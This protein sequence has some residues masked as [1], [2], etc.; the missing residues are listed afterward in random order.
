MGFGPNF[1]IGIEGFTSTSTKTSPG[2][3][4]REAARLSKE[5]TS[6]LYFH[7]MY[8]TS[9]SSNF[10]SNHQYAYKYEAMFSFIARY[11]LDV[12]WATTSESPFTSSLRIPK[13]MAIRKP[14]NSPS[15]SAILLV[16]VGLVKSILIAYLIASP[17]G[18]T[19]TTPAPV[20]FLHFA[21]S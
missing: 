20:P 1:G 9:S 4:C 10:D 6:V 3:C 7:G 12:C 18:D 2:R 8:W 11:P 17:S 16:G 15:Y 13:D 5:S 19:R 21:P 14:V